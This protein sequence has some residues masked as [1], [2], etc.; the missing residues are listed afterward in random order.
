[1]KTSCHARAALIV[2]AALALAACAGQRDPT[3]AE[4]RPIDGARAAREPLP[5]DS[6]RI[7]ARLAAAVLDDRRA[8]AVAAQ[9]ELER[10]DG[11]RAER[12][13][14]TSGL[15]DNAAELIAASGGSLAYPQ[16]ADDLLDRDD[17]DP[18]LRR[19]TELASQAD[20]LR[21]ADTRLAEERRA[22]IGGMF[23]RVVEPLSTLAITGA[24]NPLA[25]SRS[26]LSTLLALNQMPTGTPRERQALHAFEEWQETHPE[27]PDSAEVALRAAELRERLLRERYERWLKGAREAS[28]RGD[29]EA[30]FVL[31][32]RAEHM[33][34][35]GAE[36]VVLRQRAEAVLAERE[37]REHRSL[38]VRTLAPAELD[39]AQRTRFAGLARATLVAPYAEVAARA[40]EYAAAGAP[41]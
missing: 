3:P 15:A 28:A 16:R 39:A 23:N 37:A 31:A 2:C 4:W 41:A 33:R 36:A 40:N 30:A 10:E 11:L 17:L 7:A 26:A 6:E 12:G 20:L 27:H 14:A 9:S 32:Q 22:E 5:D 38:E 24:L 18:A 19:R 13:E 29:W 35:E 34:R 1:M 25:A 8:D 21:I